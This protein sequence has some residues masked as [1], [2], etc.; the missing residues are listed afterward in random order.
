MEFMGI[1]KMS[2]SLHAVLDGL[3]DMEKDPAQAVDMS[4]FG[5]WLWTSDMT[6]DGEITEEKLICYGCAATAALQKLANKKFDKRN[7]TIE[8]NRFNAVKEQHPGLNDIRFRRFEIAIDD[9]RAG[10][11]D[12][13]MK[14]F[15]I[16]DESVINAVVRKSSFLYMGD[17]WRKEVPC[18][19]GIIEY[20]EERGL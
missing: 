8:T 9:F 5:N 10:Y 2:Q 20:L 16:K 1:T 11:P 12:P 19:R 3:E 4:T 7:I 13:L 18:V 17:E 6:E 15:G 14:F